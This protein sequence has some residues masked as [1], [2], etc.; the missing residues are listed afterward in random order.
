MSTKSY[1]TE[2]LIEAIDDHPLRWEV[3]TLESALSLPTLSIKDAHTHI[4]FF[5]YPVGGPINNR[6]I[7]PPY[8]R[9]ISSLSDLENIEYQPIQPHELGQAISPDE[10]LGAEISDNQPRDEYESQL[11][12]LYALTDRLVEIYPKSIE[13]Q[14]DADRQVIENFRQHFHQIIQQPLLP[15]YKVLNPDFFK[16]LE[17]ARN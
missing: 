8:Y 17:Q 2:E 7:W 11:K 9:V 15:A 10:P 13:T 3:I 12:T 16:W 1:S 4:E 6:Q 5:F 14:S